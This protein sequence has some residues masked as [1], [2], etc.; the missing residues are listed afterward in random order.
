MSEVI[1]FFVKSLLFDV[2]RT[3]MFY[4]SQWSRV[5]DVKYNSLYYVTLFCL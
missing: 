1:C 3:V 4:F 2:Y 5:G